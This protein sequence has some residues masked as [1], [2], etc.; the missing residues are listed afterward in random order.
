MFGLRHEF[1]VETQK[2][3]GGYCSY[4]RQNGENPIPY[5]LFADYYSKGLKVKEIYREVHK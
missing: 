5:H 3:Y 1:R 4:A 2:A